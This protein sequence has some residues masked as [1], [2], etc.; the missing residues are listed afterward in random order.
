M[1]IRNFRFAPYTALD[2]YVWHNERKGERRP[3]ATSKKEGQNGG[4]NGDPKGIKAGREYDH[5][6]N[7]YSGME[8]EIKSAAKE[9]YDD[10]SRGIG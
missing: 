1:G 5:C 2:A 8:I 9:V 7:S 4:Q 3:Q 10:T 6:M